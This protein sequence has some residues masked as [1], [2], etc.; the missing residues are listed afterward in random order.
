MN[1]KT[2]V[3]R[4]QPFIE[5][6]NLDPTDFEDDIK[7]FESFNDFFYRKLTKSSRPLTTILILQFS[8]MVDI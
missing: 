8:V 3:S 4:I 6:F 7:S 2:S 5:N 1:Q